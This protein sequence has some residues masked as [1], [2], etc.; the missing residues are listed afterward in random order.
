MNAKLALFKIRNLM[1]ND[2]EILSF[3]SKI[4]VKHLINLTGALRFAYRIDSSTINSFEKLLA[5]SSSST[6]FFMENSFFHTYFLKYWPKDLIFK[7]YKDSNYIWP[8]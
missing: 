6:E 2:K 3:F 1:G 4:Q 7:R 5:K 8:N